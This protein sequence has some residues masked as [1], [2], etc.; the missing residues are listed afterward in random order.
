MVVRNL[1]IGITVLMGVETVYTVMSILVAVVAL[2]E[3]PAM[4]GVMGD[5][6]APLT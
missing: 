1:T 6:L 2:E 3:H 5:G 4:E